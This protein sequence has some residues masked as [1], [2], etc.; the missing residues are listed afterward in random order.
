MLVD[1][2]KEPERASLLYKLQKKLVQNQFISE[3]LK[4]V[5][6]ATNEDVKYLMWLGGVRSLKTSGMMQLC[7]WHATGVYPDEYDGFRY[8]KPTLIMVVGEKNENVSRINQAYLLDQRAERPADLLFWSKIKRKGGSS[9]MYS[10]VI[11]PHFNADGL[12]DGDSEIF[13]RSYEE[14]AD[15]F[16]GLN[17]IDCIFMDEE[18]PLKIYEECV[19]RLPAMQRS[20]D[21]ERKTFLFLSMWAG[22]GKTELIQRFFDNAEVNQVNNKMFYTQSGWAENP[23]FPEDEKKALRAGLA[24]YLLPA[25]EF[26]VPV[27]GVGRVFDFDINECLETPPDPIPGWWRLIAG[28]DPSVKSNGTWGGVLL[29]QD[30]ETGMIFLL[31]HYLETNLTFVE[32]TAKLINFLPKGITLV[33]DPAG[34]GETLDRESIL[35][36]IRDKSTFNVVAA[37]KAGGAKSRAINTILELHRQD[38][39]KINKEC[40]QAIEEFN[41]YSRDEQGKIIKKDDHI[42]DA[43]FYALNKIELSIDK[44]R[45]NSNYGKLQY[46]SGTDY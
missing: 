15:A 43:C 28:L 10:S 29:A 21:Q 22:K 33:S 44:N 19:R 35:D 1:L 18:P 11:V 20:G 2:Q 17:E 39:F 34:S 41:N 23:F 46:I 12:Y 9:E 40:I 7:G 5:Y 30:P 6:R 37:Y 38:L 13:F 36:Y 32:H 45:L 42:L 26:G 31:K 24:K 27:C 14:G 4:R 8:K 3:P 16:Q 25:A